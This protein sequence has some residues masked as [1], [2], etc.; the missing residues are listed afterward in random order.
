M[1]SRSIHPR[2]VHFPFHKTYSRHRSVV[3][4]YVMRAGEP[5]F[6]SQEL[7]TD[8]HGFRLR[9][10][11]EGVGFNTQNGV[12]ALVGGSTAFGVGASSDETTLPALL[13]DRGFPFI[14]LGSR[15]A[16]SIQEVILFQLVLNKI[17]NLSSVL[18][19]SGI[20]DVSLVYQLDEPIDSL[21]YGYFGS[22][23]LNKSRKSVLRSLRRRLGQ[24]KS[25]KSR[26]VPMSS[27]QEAPRNTENSDLDLRWTHMLSALGS[28][29]GFWGYFARGTNIPVTYVLQPV[30][31]WHARKPT[32]REA[33]RINADAQVVPSLRDFTSQSAYSRVRT[34]LSSACAREGIRFLDSNEWYKTG[35]ALNTDLFSDVCHMTDD[36]Y[37]LLAGQLEA[38][39]FRRRE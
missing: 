7:N 36:G 18:L 5:R 29:I 28:A 2:E 26:S 30:V 23:K 3:R 32:Q 38:N 39:A 15:G 16:T 11:L 24:L 10:S 37:A 20:N 33:E 17:S 4:P 1:T 31:G 22:K 34:F 12:G 14:N 19:L 13:T 6:R 27:D 35:T 8:E 9:G 21:F 25:A